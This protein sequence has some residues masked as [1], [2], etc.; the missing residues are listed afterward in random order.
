MKQFFTFLAAVLL[1]AT[2]SAQVGIGTT[3]PDAS[4]ALDITSTTKGLLMPRMTNA[5]RLAISTPATGL[6]IYQTDATV[7][8]YYY[9]GA[10]WSTYYSKSEVDVLIASLDVRIS[11]LEPPSIGKF[12]EG[13]IVFYIFQNGDPGYV[14]EEIHGL[15][16]AVENQS[17]GLRWHNGSGVTTNATGTAIGTGSANTDAI[18]AIQG[19]TETDYAAGLARAYNG[20]GYSDWYLP[21]IDE[22]NQMH[23]NRNTINTASSENGGSSLGTGYFW[24]SSEGSFDNA[25]RQTFNNGGNQA[26]VNKIQSFG[27]RA[28]RTF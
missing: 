28:V 12:H 6:M 3:N 8:F 15:I 13:G 14:E 21:S 23:I 25:F 18:I 4:A 27:V 5:Q 7:G 2:T 19:A 16:C 1:T 9:N 24:S 22:L 26:N 17:A 10:S 20:G 11:A